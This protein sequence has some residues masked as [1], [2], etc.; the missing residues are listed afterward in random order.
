M[1]SRQ[2]TLALLGFRRPVL[3]KQAPQDRLL[4]FAQPTPAQRKTHHILRFLKF[5]ESRTATL[6]QMPGL[7][8]SYSAR[9]TL[10]ATPGGPHSVTRT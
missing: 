3:A 7:V 5:P 1:G 6:P 2:H 10:P 8:D 9:C 4:G